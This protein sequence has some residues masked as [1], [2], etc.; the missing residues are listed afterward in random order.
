MVIVHPLR[1]HILCTDR[2]QIIHVTLIVSNWVVYLGLLRKRLIVGTDF[3]DLQLTKRKTT[4]TTIKIPRVLIISTFL[5]VQIDHISF[6]NIILCHIIYN[7]KQE[8]IKNYT[9]LDKIVKQQS[10]PKAFKVVIASLIFI[11]FDNFG[12]KTFLRGG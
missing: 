5:V 3:R 10:S 12:S 9:Y 4:T 11:V 2:K 6:L 7:Y 1:T 8:L